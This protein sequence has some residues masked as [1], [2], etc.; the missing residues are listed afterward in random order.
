MELLNAV[1]YLLS[2]SGGAEVDSLEHNLP[3]INAARIRIDEAT[4]TL[5]KRGWWFNTDP[6]V[7]LSPDEG[8]KEIT[9]TNILKVKGLSQF[10]TLQNGK[11]YDPHTRS[12]E[13]SGDVTVELVNSYPWEFLPES[14]QDYIMYKAGHDMV[15]HELEDLNKAQYLSREVQEAM[16]QLKKE[17]IELQPRNVLNTP[18]VQGL[19][20]R[21]KPYR[22]NRYI[23]PNYPGGRA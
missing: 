9:L 3:D 10:V 19:R 11:L 23:N 4:R 13:F 16:L 17:E 6:C 5:L 2:L 12:Y 15:V 22:Q 1:N 14:A 7:T 21:V 8:T 20:S 18:S